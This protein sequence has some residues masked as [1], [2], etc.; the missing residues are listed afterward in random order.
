MFTAWK[1]LSISAVLLSTCLGGSAFRT[2]NLFTL[3]Q[4]ET[5]TVYTRYGQPSEI[6]LFKNEPLKL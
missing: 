4:N 2:I 6:R 3:V 5:V 1:E